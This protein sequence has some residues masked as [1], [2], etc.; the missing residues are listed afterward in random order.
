[1][2]EE[3]F[4]QLPASVL[5]S[6]FDVEMNNL[7]H[8]LITKK[9]FCNHQK[10]YFK[11]INS[12]LEKSSNINGNQIYKKD[13][14]IN[15][16][17]NSIELKELKKA[18]KFIIF[19][20]YTL[21]LIFQENFFGKAF[22]M[23]ILIQKN[24]EKKEFI[25]NLIQIKCSDTFTIDEVSLPFQVEFIKQKFSILFNINICESYVLYL[26]IF[27]LPKKFALKNKDK[28]FL[29]NINEEK[30]VDF[31]N[32]EYKNFPILPGAIIQN[33]DESFFLL[34]IK[35]KLQEINGNIIKLKFIKNIYFPINNKNDIYNN[36][37]ENQ[38]YIIVKNNIF[39]S[40]FKF[41]NEKGYFEN[42]QSNNYKIKFNKI[43]SIT[44]YK[45]D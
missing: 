38:I 39:N 16:I 30:F 11:D 9:I 27:E 26:S 1:M 36:L 14:V 4:L 33:L 42:K 2:K 43:F 15:F 13:D 8:K 37:K 22:D 7:F 31:N 28:T 34:E 18:I 40:Y 20:N 45:D 24:K 5:G 12:I 41:N 23:L 32:K 3:K 44:I 17:N 25:M 6:N 19:N 35:K 10:K 29:Y 21:I